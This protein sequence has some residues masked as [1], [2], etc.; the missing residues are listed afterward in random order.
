[1]KRFKKLICKYF[2]HK[3]SDWS[4][5]EKPRHRRCLRCPYMELE[6]TYDPTLI[7]PQY[8]NRVD[9]ELDVVE[10]KMEFKII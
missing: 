8:L 6:I 10:G 9:K 1:M 4:T 5:P 3:F 7:T 2:G